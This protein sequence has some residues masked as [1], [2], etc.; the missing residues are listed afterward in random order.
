MSDLI[1]THLET[2]KA[3]L[4]A[5]LRSAAP[6]AQW[7]SVGRNELTNW[8]SALDTSAAILRSNGEAAQKA[9]DAK[10]QREA[11]TDYH[12]DLGP[13]PAAKWCKGPHPNKTACSFCGP[14]IESHV[15]HKAVY[16]T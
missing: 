16:G 3:Q 8:I 9:R 2:I 15:M 12:G 6:R 10:A 13:M 1:A 11:T 7:I 5:R 14:I 4:E